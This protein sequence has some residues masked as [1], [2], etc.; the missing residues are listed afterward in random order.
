MFDD[1]LESVSVLE[2]IEQGFLCPLRSKVTEIQYDLEG[3]KKRGGEYI[4][5]EL[6]K[7]LD[8]EPYNIA[9]CQEI[10]AIAEKDQRK[11]WLVFCTGVQHAEHVASI[12]R[13]YGVTAQ[14][15]TGDTPKA[16]REH[17]LA[18]F[19]AGRIQCM[20]N[21]NVLTTGFDAPGIDL[22][23]MLRPTMSPTLYVQMAGRGLRTADSKS[24]C[25]V[26]DFAGNVA[27]HGP[28]TDVVIPTTTGEKKGDGEAP[29][30]VC[31]NCH[32][33]VALG[34]QACP[35]C[36]TP[37]EMVDREIDPSL[38]NDD[39]L[40][41]EDEETAVYTWQW[42]VHHS[43]NSG[44]HMLKVKYY[45]AGY[46]QTVIEYITVAHDGWAGQKGR[47]IMRQI[48]DGCG[49]T[50][51][52]PDVYSVENM[53]WLAEHLSA[54]CQP[55]SE[56]K[57]RVEGGYRRVIERKWNNASQMVSTPRADGV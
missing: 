33:I 19:K 42:Y 46:T 11:S 16:D 10:M 20:T 28:I 13:A 1:I 9:V 30:K 5:S 56:I 25:L 6:I 32:E 40:K 34:T 38:R 48:A 50:F 45:P 31:D 35:A 54:E 18:E 14:H 26:L 8:T 4:E 15:V 12:M 49:L 37:F 52:L 24:D 44:K 22:I 57:H 23:A 41:R 39:I 21:A 7:R 47:R 3:V 43:K 2:L 36:G 17:Y 55:P 53:K 27:E 51:P 29:T